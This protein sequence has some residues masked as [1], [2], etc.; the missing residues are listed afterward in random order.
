M[1]CQSPRPADDEPLNAAFDD[2]PEDYDALRAT[3]HMA[4]RRLDH[5]AGV[6]AA[7]AGDVLEIG[8]GTGTLLRALAAAHP[9]RRFVGIDPLPGYTDYAR[10]LAGHEGLTNVA[11][12]TGTGEELDRLVPPR[13]FGLVISV[14]ALHHVTDVDRVV[15]GARRAT[16]DGAR[17]CLMEPN[18][19]HPYVWLYH[20]LT[21]GERTFPVR[22]FLRRSRRGGWTPAGR[23]TMFALPSGVPRLPAALGRAERWLERIPPLAGAVVLDLRR[24]PVSAARDR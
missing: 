21:P 3:G 12:A 8:C 20:A 22:D 23:R 11:F 19:W 18:R 1:A 4:R 13:S 16:A 24:G 9:D 5:F 15:A 17:W 7:C 2:R 14:D 6:V 10:R